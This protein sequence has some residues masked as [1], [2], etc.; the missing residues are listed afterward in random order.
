MPVVLGRLGLSEVVQSYVEDSNVAVR[1]NPS[2]I[3]LVSRLTEL[4]LRPLD[5][6]PI[7]ISLVHPIELY[8]LRMRHI[9]QLIEVSGLPFLL[10]D[11]VCQVIL[12]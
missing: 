1:P 8:G 5:A 2:P 10:T 3:R 6:N 4:F 12:S 7:K 9:A 11:L